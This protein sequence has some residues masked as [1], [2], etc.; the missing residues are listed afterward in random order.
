MML[1]RTPPNEQSLPLLAMMTGHGKAIEHHTSAIPAHCRH[2]LNRSI[3][4]TATHVWWRTLSESCTKTCSEHASNGESSQ[5]CSA[6][7]Y[8]QVT[9]LDTLTSCTPKHLNQEKQHSC[10]L[11]HANS[12]RNHGADLDSYVS[13]CR[14]H[15]VGYLNWGR[16]WPIK[17]I[18]TVTMSITWPRDWPQG[19][20]QK[21]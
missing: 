12:Y 5:L 2:E 10:P 8:Y 4:P 7:Y 17:I 14:A 9:R 16:I 13:T 21:F 20:Y 3:H 15:G 19:T 11:L 6:H 18:H 1:L